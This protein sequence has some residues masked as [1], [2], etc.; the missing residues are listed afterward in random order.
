MIDDYL[1]K[2]ETIISP[3]TYDLNNYKDKILN[4]NLVF[5][6]R[7][8]IEGNEEFDYN[9]N[10]GKSKIEMNENM[11][12][13]FSQ[14]TN[15]QQYENYDSDKFRQKVHQLNVKNMAYRQ[16]IDNLNRKIED[17]NKLIESQRRTIEE[18]KLMIE[19]NSK[20]LL[21]L[22][23]YLVEAGKNKAREKFTLN[24]L[25]INNK[26]AEACKDSASKATFSVE[27]NEMKE[28]IVSL[29]NE[30]QKLKEFQEKVIELSKNFDEI[31]YTI[32][33]SIKEIE[34]NLSSINSSNNNEALL[35]EINNNVN[36]LVFCFEETLKSKHYEY[37]SVMEA[38][39][40]E[41]EFLR[42]EII[43]LNE[44]LEN[45]KKDRMKDQKNMIELE[46]Q[47]NHLH[48]EIEDLNKT[49]NENYTKLKL[50]DSENISSK[51]AVRIFFIKE[52]N[53]TL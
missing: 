46:C 6:D 34:N 18:N 42:K 40:S 45:V 29:V 35:N 17:Q 36:K 38:K 32:I 53:R 19:N 15:S 28:M 49:I 30:N 43:D 13:H 8:F 14:N 4:S 27:R 26:F 44:I 39:E 47:N 22:E 1:K 37:Y 20:Y 48:Q 31:N 51:I 11:S 12:Q 9:S 5:P 3:Q 33:E 25:G 52:K 24:L 41:L 16:K 7:N 50:L 21:K 10:L 2:L 23:S